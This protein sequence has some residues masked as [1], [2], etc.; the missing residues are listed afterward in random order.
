MLQLLEQRYGSHGIGTSGGR[1]GMA[2]RVRQADARPV[3]VLVRILGAEIKR[4]LRV[5]QS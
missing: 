5:L 1:E 3:P 2:E 4:R